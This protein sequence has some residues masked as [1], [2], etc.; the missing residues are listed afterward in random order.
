[1]EETFSTWVHWPRKN[2]GNSNSY[3]LTDAS[4]SKSAYYRLRIVEKDA[5][6]KWSRVVK[7]DTKT[8]ATISV[9]PNPVEAFVSV[10]HGEAASNARLEVYSSIGEKL[11][12]VSVAK[13]DTHTVIQLAQLPAGTFIVHYLDDKKEAKQF[14]IKQ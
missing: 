4:F 2:T 1:M 8:S 9:Y 11:H 5:R 6:E 3:S 7:L 10:V 14:I 12:S 13:G